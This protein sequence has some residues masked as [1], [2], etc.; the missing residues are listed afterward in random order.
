[1][2]SRLERKLVKP[3]SILIEQTAMKLACEFYEI[4]KNQGLTSKFKTHKAYARRH[5]NEFIPLA[6]SHL[7]DILANPNT[8][9][10]QRNMIMDAFLER[11]NDQ[12]LS[13]TIP[14]F[15][16]PFAKD[17]VSDKVVPQKPL[18]GTSPNSIDDLPLESMLNP[19]EHLNG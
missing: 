8:P 13:Q 18:V 11:A 17:F 1:M 14:L 4:G 10:D 6:V 15:D 9:I 5:I 12:D 16:N 3:E 7:M 19:K 2:S